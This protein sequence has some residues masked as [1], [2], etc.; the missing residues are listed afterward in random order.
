MQNESVGFV[1]FIGFTEIGN[2]NLG[3]HWNGDLFLNISVF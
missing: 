3:E 2:G 1:G